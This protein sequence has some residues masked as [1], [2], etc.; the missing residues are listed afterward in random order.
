MGGF[1]T[2]VEIDR[3]LAGNVV[4]NFDVVN[5]TTAEICGN[6]IIGVNIPEGWLEVSRV[7]WERSCTI[8]HVADHQRHS[9]GQ[10]NGVHRPP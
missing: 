6:N 9:V 4:G 5:L 8:P 1:E 10:N 3:P 7:C 2:G